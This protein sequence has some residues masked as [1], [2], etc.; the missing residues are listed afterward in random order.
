MPASIGSCWPLATGATSIDRLPVLDGRGH[1][2][3]LDLRRNPF[4]V[5]IE[6]WQHDLNIGT[7]VR[8]ANAFL[9]AEVHIVGRRDG[10]AEGRW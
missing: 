8:T 9:A 6:N 4:H 3:D 7:V 5:V 10:T 2:D 1:R